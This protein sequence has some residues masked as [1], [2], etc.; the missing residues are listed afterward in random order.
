MIDEIRRLIVGASHRGGAPSG[1]F[2]QRIIEGFGD[3]R[4]HREIEGGIGVVLGRCT[5]G[6]PDGPQLMSVVA[7]QRGIE[8]VGHDARVEGQTAAVGIDHLPVAQLFRP[9]VGKEMRGTCLARARA[10][11]ERCDEQHQSITRQRPRATQL[12]GSSIAASLGNSHW[13]DAVSTFG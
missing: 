1:A 5:G 4:A 11:G 3:H 9:A 10:Q 2:R 6:H 12:L 7:E 13:K 8:I